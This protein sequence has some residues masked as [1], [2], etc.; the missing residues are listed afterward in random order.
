M[1]GKFILDF[2][3]VFHALPDTGDAPVKAWESSARVA[4]DFAI[5]RVQRLIVVFRI[6]EMFV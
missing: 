2:E 4:K 6:T 3:K 1:C 5:S